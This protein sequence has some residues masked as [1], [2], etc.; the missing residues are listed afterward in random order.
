MAITPKKIVAAQQL[1]TVIATYYTTPSAIVTIVDKFTLTN[2]TS[3]AITATVYMVDASGT[4]GASECLISARTLASGE[5]YT[6]PEI[7]GHILN[8]GDTIQA[9][10]SANSALTVR[11]SGRE[12]SGL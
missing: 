9:L 5:T 3:A 11:I 6:C 7:V 12:V 2:T 1:T 10:A 8:H 4:A